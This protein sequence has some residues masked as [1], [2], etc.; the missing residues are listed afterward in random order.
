MCIRDRPWADQ[1]PDNGG[2]CDIIIEDCTFGFCHGVLTC[3]SESI[4]NH[5]IILRR[6]N[7]DQAKRLLWLKMRPDTPQQYKYIL[8]EARLLFP[9][10]KVVLLKQFINIALAIDDFT[11]YLDKGD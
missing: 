9:T 4:Y 2:N 1:D 3:G 11:F 6:C 5:N 10:F 7:L 8:V